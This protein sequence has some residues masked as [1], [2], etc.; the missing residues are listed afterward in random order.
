MKA[1][2]L[3]LRLELLEV[4]DSQLNC[5]SEYTILGQET[6]LLEIAKKFESQM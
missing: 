5:L 6:N 1:I 2:E 3:E 4:K